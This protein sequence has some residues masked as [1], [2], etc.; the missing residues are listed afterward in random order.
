MQ[1]TNLQYWPSET[2][3]LD[4]APNVTST[5][6]SVEPPASINITKVITLRTS[7]S[8][9]ILALFLKDEDISIS[10]NPPYL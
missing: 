1:V 3:L 8:Q 6:V 5:S 2:K 9:T 4:K 7:K 10:I